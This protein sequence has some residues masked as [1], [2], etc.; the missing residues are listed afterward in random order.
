M[1]DLNKR[2]NVLYPQ[3]MV[4]NG[5]Y[6]FRLFRSVIFVFNICCH[7]LRLGGEKSASST[8]RQ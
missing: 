4:E 5:S 8:G 7:Y 2:S 3:H 6:L 1:K